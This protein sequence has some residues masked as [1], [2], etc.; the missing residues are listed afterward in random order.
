M[1]YRCTQL[2]LR[3]DVFCNNLHRFVSIL[4]TKCPNHAEVFLEVLQLSLEQ[5]DYH[6]GHEFLSKKLET[7]IIGSARERGRSEGDRSLDDERDLREVVR[8]IPIP[9]VRMQ[10]YRHC[11]C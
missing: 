4:K 6:L 10:P 11:G 7:V 9:G 8:Q 5:E 3:I 1:Y 2:V